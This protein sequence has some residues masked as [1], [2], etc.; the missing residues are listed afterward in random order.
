VQ[1][2]KE[3]RAKLEDQLRATELR[4]QA[5]NMNLSASNGQLTAELATVTARSKQLQV[6]RCIC[7]TTCAV[8]CNKIDWAGAMRVYVQLPSG[9]GWVCAGVRTSGAQQGLPG[10]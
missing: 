3:A 2:E 7:T 9:S 8:Y 10:T 5:D 6:S 1:V 4:T